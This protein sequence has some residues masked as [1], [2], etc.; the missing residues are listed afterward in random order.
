MLYS[1]AAEGAARESCEGV[2]MEARLPPRL[3]IGMCI[4]ARMTQLDFTA[5]FEVFSR[6]DGA[7]AHVIARSLDPVKSDTGLAILPTT[8]LQTCPQPLD[9]LF[10]PGGPG[11]VD[12]IEDEEFLSFVRA[13]GAQ[14]R[15]V[16][17][18]C[19]GSLVLGAAGLLRGYRATTHWT[20]MDCLAG[21]GAIPQHSRVV[22]DRNRITGAGVTAGIDFA[23]SVAAAVAGEAAAKSI[24]LLLEYDP[25]PPFDAGSPA[26]AGPELTEAILKRDPERQRSRLDAIERAV[27]RLDEGCFAHER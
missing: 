3:S 2:W 26:A 15:F 18:V 14:A 22:F 16:T 20:S 5:P 8:T 12:R 1:G 6:I 19:T 11:H 17:S 13:S 4:Y 24:Q 27:R 23:L 25:K 10:I 21:F 9:I 7:E